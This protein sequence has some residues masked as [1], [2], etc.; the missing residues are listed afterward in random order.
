M[1]ATGVFQSIRHQTTCSGTPKMVPKWVPNRVVG[2]GCVMQLTQSY[3]ILT[4]NHKYALCIPWFIH[5]FP[6]RPN[7]RI[8]G[9]QNRY[10]EP[11]SRRAYA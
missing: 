3:R 4:I 8:S 9:P 1:H 5:L 6:G 11:M 10:L 2:T 7:T